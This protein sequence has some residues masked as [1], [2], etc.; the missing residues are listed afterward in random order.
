M[1]EDVVG[2]LVGFAFFIPIVVICLVAEF[3]YR[4]KH[5]AEY[6]NNTIDNS[7]K[8][9]TINN[10]Y[11]NSVSSEKIG[12]FNK[13]TGSIEKFIL[14][15]P[16]GNV[17][18][19]LIHKTSDKWIS[20]SF[21]DNGNKEIVAELYRNPYDDNKLLR[22]KIAGICKGFY[23]NGHL[24]FA[25]NYVKGVRQGKME[26]YYDNG[27]T[28]MILNYVDGEPTDGL[29]YSLEGE[30]KPLTMAHINNIIN[31]YNVGKISINVSWIK[32]LL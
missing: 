11:K 8:K 13:Y 18:H 30:V 12:S 32:E 26:F 24:K 19:E 9:K 15:Y 6:S 23:P 5:S 25:V 2:I 17:K 14:Y 29:V 31:D 10:T 28:E 7:K 20:T 1:N 16:D 3:N 21:Y 22:F 4:K 27:D